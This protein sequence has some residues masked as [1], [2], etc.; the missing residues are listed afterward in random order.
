MWLC[1]RQLHSLENSLQISHECSP[2]IHC[3]PKT[4][5]KLLQNFHTLPELLQ[6]HSNAGPSHIP[7]HQLLPTFLLAKYC[8]LLTTRTKLTT[9]L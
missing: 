9:S 8:M 7:P 3:I 2:G 1:V 4:E 5:G 6:E